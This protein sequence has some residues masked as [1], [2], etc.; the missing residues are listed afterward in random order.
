MSAGRYWGA[1]NSAD[2]LGVNLAAI[3]LGS[4]LEHTS[5]EL[6]ACGADLVYVADSDLLESYRS[7]AYARILADLVIEHHP[8]ILLLGSTI[9]GRDLAP[10]LLPE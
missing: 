1:Q 6:I 8:D 10:R 2:R 7:E 5:S 3:L 9:I 4:G